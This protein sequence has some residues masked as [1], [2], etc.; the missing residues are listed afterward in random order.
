MRSGSGYVADVEQWLQAVPG[1][2]LCK[3][4]CG[5]FLLLVTPIESQLEGGSE[6]I[7]VAC[8]EIRA[9]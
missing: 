3:L 9:M 2:G 5:S 1:L 4:Y 6:V 7:R 8:M